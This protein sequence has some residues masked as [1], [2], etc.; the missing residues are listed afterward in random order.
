MKRTKVE[1]SPGFVLMWALF[2]FFDKDSV[3]LWALAACVVHELAHIVTLYAVGGQMGK[4]RLTVFGA[5]ITGASRKKLSYG[6]E[7]LSVLAGPG[8]NLL[9]ALITARAGER[10]YLFSGLN[11]C[12]GIFNL[13]PVPGL[14]GGRVMRLLFQLLREEKGQK[15]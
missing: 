11:L 8:V 3:A 1:I 15:K 4:L 13:L 6:G 7:V 14:D 10:W 2:L 12:L 5:E 9:L